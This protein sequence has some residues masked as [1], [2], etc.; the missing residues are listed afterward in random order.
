[1]RRLGARLESGA[2]SVYW[3][4]ANKEELLDLAMDEALAEVAIPEP[5]GDWR[6]DL[7]AL[8]GGLRAMMSAHPWT[9]RLYHSR[10]LFGQH[11]LRYAEAQLCLLRSAGFAGDELDGAF[12]MV[13]DYVRGSVDAAGPQRSRP[14]SRSGRVS[15][16][17]TL[18][19]S[20]QDAANPYPALRGYREHIRCH[21][22]ECLLQQR[23]DFG[24]R[25][26]LDGLSARL[27]DGATA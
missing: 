9:T 8:L 26:L 4:V 13:V 1:M 21:D 23:F 6:A 2:T 22:R 7:R 18:E 24:L 12:N 17:M 19:A 11:A 10:P 14:H 20:L 25:V 16:R 15:D 27:R 5:T 3:Y